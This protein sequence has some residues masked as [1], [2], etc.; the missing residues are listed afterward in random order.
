MDC[1]C[2]CS[3]SKSNGAFT[4]LVVALL[5]VT[6]ISGLG[7]LLGGFGHMLTMPRDAWL[8]LSTVGV[9]G[10]VWGLWTGFR[11][12]GH[13]EPLALGIIGLAVAGAGFVLSHSL[14]VGGIALSLGAALWSMASHRT[15]TNA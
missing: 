2:C 1:H 10:T 15:Q 8:P 4:F 12:H 5:A 7:S 11:T 13:A 14:A 3:C 9:G 6:F